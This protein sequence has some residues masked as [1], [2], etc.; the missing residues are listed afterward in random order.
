MHLKEYHEFV[1]DSAMLD[2]NFKKAY[3]EMIQ[4]MDRSDVESF[5]NFIPFDSYIP[6]DNGLDE[7][8][9]RCRSEGINLQLSFAD[10]RYYLYTYYVDFNKLANEDVSALACGKICIIL[11]KGDKE[12]A[13]KNIDITVRLA[14]VKDKFRML[15]DRVDREKYNGQTIR[16][17]YTLNQEY[18]EEIMHNTKINQNII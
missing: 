9:F 13:C 10:E 3:L 4:K 14:K 5:I 12:N 16:Q 15:V 8:S 6:S 1:I 7:I 2:E 17:G 11:T 18:V